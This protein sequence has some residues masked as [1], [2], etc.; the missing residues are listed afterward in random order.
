MTS[1]GELFLN[2]LSGIYHTTLVLKKRKEGRNILSITTKKGRLVED[3]QSKV[4][5]I[6]EKHELDILFLQ[7][8]VF[9]WINSLY[10][11]PI[12]GIKLDLL[13]V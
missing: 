6:R 5:S 12:F 2:P 9:I 13:Y 10:F 4:N 8:L 3:Y 11:F 7:Y 1:Y